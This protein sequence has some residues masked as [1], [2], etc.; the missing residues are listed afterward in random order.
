M[1]LFPCVGMRHARH[2]IWLLLG[3]VC[4]GW[5]HCVAPPVPQ[6]E[7]PEIVADA[8]LQQSEILPEAD[9]KPESQPTEPESCQPGAKRDC[10]LSGQGMCKQ[11]FQNCE[12]S[13]TWGTCIAANQPTEEVCDQR[14][15]DCDGEI[16]EDCCK[17]CCFPTKVGPLFEAP[18][19]YPAH[20]VSPDLKWIAYKTNDG[21]LY[22]YDR[23]TGKEINR[24]GG[25]D[26]IVTA[27]QFVLFHPEN[28]WVAY[29]V[30]PSITNTIF[31]GFLLE[32]PKTGKF[33]RK[34]TEI[35]QK[36]KEDCNKPFC[37]RIEVAKFSSASNTILA[38]FTSSIK[39]QGN[40]LERRWL[41]GWDV[42]TG[43]A[44]KYFELPPTANQAAKG[45][46]H[47]SFRPIVMDLSKNGKHMFV[48]N[49]VSE[50]EIWD[51]EAKQ[52]IAVL[53]PT[54]IDA[55]QHRSWVSS[56]SL[57]PDE[58]KLSVTLYG[59]EILIW[60]LESKTLQKRFP[61]AE[62]PNCSYRTCS[63]IPQSVCENSIGCLAVF[64]RFSPDG[65]WLAAYDNERNFVQIFE[66]KSFSLYQ[67]FPPVKAEHKKG[68]RGPWVQAFQ[69]SKD[70]KQ[71]V[72]VD[73]SKMHVRSYQC[74]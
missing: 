27:S 30:P 39:N 69:W 11:G 26:P 45:I 40:D 71:F 59:G 18:Q 49:T 51:L 29:T 47:A 21:F 28:K 43:K 62:K 61:L 34:L 44:T 55:R 70:S 8:G 52:R 66:T 25:S 6:N 16:D 36:M 41:L 73:Q 37:L 63:K 58:S 23:L 32:E 20:A 65:N 7:Q 67:T 5:V 53:T 31:Y 35:P 22:L 48:G 13:G 9:T 56:L 24:I 72:F 74:P 57:H 60:D 1:S 33:I 10:E 42:E 64:A 68:S 15:N 46:N 38:I 12:Q 19:V 54:N 14:D 50:V 3:C 2:L 4:L 17:D